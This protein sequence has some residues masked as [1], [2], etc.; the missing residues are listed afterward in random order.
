MLVDLLRQVH[1]PSVRCRELMY[2]GIFIWDAFL[3]VKRLRKKLSCAFFLRNRFFFLRWQKSEV[4]FD[5]PTDHV[6]LL[7][8]TAIIIWKPWQMEWFFLDDPVLFFSKSIFSNV[9]AVCSV[10]QKPLLTNYRRPCLCFTR[11][12]LAEECIRQRKSIDCRSFGFARWRPFTDVFQRAAKS[13]N[14]SPVKTSEKW[15]TPGTT[16]HFSHRLYIY[17][18]ALSSIPSGLY[19]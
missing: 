3:G 12:C 19:L 1:S 4:D 14:H 13:L 18:F 2:T 9:R 10:P 7:W 5:W 17:R 11:K 15:W 6:Q 8:P 16:F